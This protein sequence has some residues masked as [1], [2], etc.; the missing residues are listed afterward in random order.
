MPELP[1]VE[2][3]TR[4]LRAAACGAEISGCGFYRSS[5]THPQE[6]RMLQRGVRG[7]RIEGVDRRGKHILV[8]LSGGRVLRVHLRMT[9][10]LVV[11]PDCRLRPATARAWFEFA[12]GRAM[13]LD[14]SRALGRVSVHREEDLG[15]LLDSLGPEPLSPEFTVACLREKARAS[16]KPAKIFLMD[17]KAVAGLGNIYAAEA[18]YQARIDPRKPARDV[19]SRKVEA[20]HAAIVGVLRIALDSAIAA[21]DTPGGFSEGESFPVAVYGREGEPCPACGAA[22]RRITQGGRSTYFCA[23]CQK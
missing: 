1:E 11:I 21:Y 17:Q 14:D 13:V 7:R 15:E 20:L 9:G 22:I 18:L 12:D 19:S 6:P 2:A 4:K 3:V 16:R 10:N 5:V 23:R 8:R